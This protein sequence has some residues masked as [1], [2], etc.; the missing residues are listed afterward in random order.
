[1][2]SE[3]LDSFLRFG[4]REKFATASLRCIVCGEETRIVGRVDVQE[5]AYSVGCKP[6]VMA[7]SGQVQLGGRP[8]R[9]PSAR[10]TTADA[11]R[12]DALLPG[13]QYVK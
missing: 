3:S 12:H 5:R 8:P 11:C 2:W 6:R 13:G 7:V 10:T 4:L 9:V 1:M